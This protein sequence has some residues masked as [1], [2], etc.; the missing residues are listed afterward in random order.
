[1][2]R[3]PPESD[4]SSLRNQVDRLA[5]ILHKQEEQLNQQT[6]GTSLGAPFEP[7]T[8]GCDPQSLLPIGWK[9]IVDDGL[10]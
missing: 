8:E 4:I 10:P 6:G 9:Q 3:A 1:M 5:N 7:P 2:H